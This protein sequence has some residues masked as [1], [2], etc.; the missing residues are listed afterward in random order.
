VSLL[1]RRTP[2]PALAVIGTA[3]LL[4]GGTVASAATTSKVWSATV[5]NGPTDH[6][7]DGDTVAVRVDEDPSSLTAPHIR[8]TGIPTMEL[9][10]CHAAEAT[11]AMDRLVTG[12]RVRMTTNSTTTSSL[13]RP[14]RRIDTFSG[15]TWVGQR[16]D[17]LPS[18]G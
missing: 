14:V 15:S 11:T 2:A 4:I 16:A 9:R 1:P 17:H 12:R 18:V 13:G 3:A 5:T 10:S 7:V 6:T 8:D